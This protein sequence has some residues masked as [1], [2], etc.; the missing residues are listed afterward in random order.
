MS[1]IEKIKRSWW[2]LISFIIMLNGLGF[3]YVGFSKNNRNWII[4]G[5]IYEIPW[6]FSIF[7]A[8]DDLMVYTFIR[9]ALVL[10][11][12]SIIRSFW[13]AIKLADV[14]DNEDKYTVRP[15]VINNHNNPKR[16]DN[17]LTSFGCCLCL[18][19]IFVM[20]VLVANL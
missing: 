12:I 14:Y 5:I 11:L 9:L 16:N 7:Y 3:I 18:I 8:Y 19:V 4:E 17:F 10:M 6:L 1:I 2:I 15:T 20:F 13:V